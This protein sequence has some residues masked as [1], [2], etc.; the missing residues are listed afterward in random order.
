MLRGLAVLLAL[1]ALTPAHAIGQ[2]SSGLYANHGYDTR[3]NPY[4]DLEHALTRA[5]AEDKHVL[6]VVGGDWCVWCEILDRFLDRDAVVRAVFEDTFVML[7]VNWSRENENE[8]FLSGFPESAGFPDFF[9]IDR[10][11][12]FV[13]QQRTDVLER[14]RDY[15]R[16]RMLAFAQ[17]WR[18]D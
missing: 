3:A 9:I 4:R 16:A 15:D 5:A 11:G 14:G 13:A 10:N 8:A 17:Q 18:R 6:L 1:L 2:T 7:K 12:A